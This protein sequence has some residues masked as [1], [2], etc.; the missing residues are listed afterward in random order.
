MHGVTPP[1]SI[2]L[3]GVVLNWA[4]W[5]L[6]LLFQIF[7]AWEPETC[8]EHEWAFFFYC[9]TNKR[10]KLLFLIVEWFWTIW[11]D[12]SSKSCKTSED[13]RRVFKSCMVRWYVATGACW[14]DTEQGWWGRDKT[15]SNRFWRGIILCWCFCC[16]FCKGNLRYKLGVHYWK[17]R[18]TFKWQRL[19]NKEDAFSQELHFLHRMTLHKAQRKIAMKW[20]NTDAFIH[21]HQ[22]SHTLNKLQCAECCYM[23]DMK[24]LWL[25]Q[26]RLLS[27]R[28]WHHVMRQKFTDWKNLPSSSG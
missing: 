7:S 5:H 6:C 22:Q 2:C 24:F 26:W 14:E 16:V 27:S 8:H 15:G 21:F 4:Q 18:H 10:S 28:M 23:W 20:M 13:Q 3:H 25:W 17:W 9:K 19:E 11:K 1:L 12:N